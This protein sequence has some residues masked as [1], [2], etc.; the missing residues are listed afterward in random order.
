[1]AMADVDDEQRDLA[2][3]PLD[4]AFPTPARIPHFVFL[5]KE[6][7]CLSRSTW[8]KSI[9]PY[10]QLATSAFLT[11]LA[12]VG[13]SYLT[14]IG[15]EATIRT[16]TGM[17]GKAKDTRTAKRAGKFTDDDYERTAR[18]ALAKRYHLSDSELT[19]KSIAVGRDGKGTVELECPI[20]GG[21]VTVDVE[22]HGNGLR[23]YHMKRAN[24]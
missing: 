10:A 3:A 20:L 4:P 16:L 6:S 11:F 9:S 2:N 8:T 7:G 23:Q 1:M 24:S 15:I 13:A 19:V 17:T 5:R 18:Q 21:S 12:E 14:G 22:L